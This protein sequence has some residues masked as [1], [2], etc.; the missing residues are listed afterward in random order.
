MN[1]I[2]ILDCTLRDGGYV[3]NWSFGKKII[4]ECADKLYQSKV[5]IVECGFLSQIKAVDENKSIFESISDAE[6]CI[7]SKAHNLAL[8]INVGEYNSNDIPSYKGGAVSILRIAFH[9]HQQDEARAL[10]I[11][12]KSKGYIVFFQPMVT[13]NY[14]DFELLQLI[15]WANENQPDG[16]YIVDSFGTMRS[17]D[18]LRMFYLVDNNLNKDIMIGFHSHNNL[19]LSFSNAQE[20]IHIDSKRDIIIDTSVF[21]MGRGAGNLCTELMTQYINENIEYKYDLIPILEIMDEFIMPIYAR[22]PWGYSAPYYVAAINGCHPNYAT[23][24]VNRQSLCIRDINSIIKS[25]PTDKKTLFDSELIN[26]LYLQYQANNIDDNDTIRNIANLCKDR[27]VL[28]IAPGKSELTCS[29]II[30]DFIEK[31]NP[32]VFSVNHIPEGFKCDRV[33]VSN[34]KRFKNIY[35]A[36]AILKSSL[37]CTSNISSASGISAV[38]YSNYLNDSGIISDNAGLMLINV[39]KK[40]GVTSL[41][42]A[43]YDGFSCSTAT[44]YYDEKMINDVN[45][46][47]QEEMNKS[48]TEYFKKIRCFIDVTF[49]TP[50]I[51]EGRDQ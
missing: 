29:D 17:N 31:N 26:E 7:S 22:H 11:D 24:L 40:A 49:I 16:L 50:S 34:L 37:I 20:L 41:N 12:L 18:L 5:E 42:L 6:K 38:N 43:G 14:S 35:D 13:M 30:Q 44:N 15:E 39:L 36:A 25:I 2:K 28:I 47:R 45:F 33:F 48:I 4:S 3:N 1:L 23:D 51:Y 19:Q 10:C 32:V 8:M 21:G 9:K 46:E 27:N